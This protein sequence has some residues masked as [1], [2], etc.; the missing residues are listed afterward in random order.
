MHKVNEIGLDD[1]SSRGD[2]RGGWLLRNSSQ[3]VQSA[4]LNVAQ[5]SSLINADRYE[6]EV[7]DDPSQSYRRISII[8]MVEIHTSVN[9]LMVSTLVR[10]NQRKEMGGIP[11]RCEGLQR[12]SNSSQCTERERKARPDTDRDSPT[13]RRR[14]RG[15]G[16]S[17]RWSCGGSSALRQVEEGS[18]IVWAGLDGIDCEHHALPTVAS[19][20][21][22]APDRRSLK[23][24][25][26]T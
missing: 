9:I 2:V 23:E 14:W 18:E 21:T 24:M 10:S 5:V 4:K 1:Y 26:G 17:R 13:S 25:R 15:S 7:G 16:G 22:V 12:K 19:L 20:T 6:G 8:W 11:I 3:S